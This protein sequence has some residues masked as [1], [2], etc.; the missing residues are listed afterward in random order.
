MNK[1]D[2]GVGKGRRMMGKGRRGKEKG[3]EVM[4]K[5]KKSK[6]AVIMSFHLP[7]NKKN[8]YLQE[9]PVKP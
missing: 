8:N 7:H 9:T 1:K 6:K 4:E 5:K 3:K 2:K